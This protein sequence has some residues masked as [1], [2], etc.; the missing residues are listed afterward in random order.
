MWLGYPSLHAELQWHDLSVVCYADF[1]DALVEV[2]REFEPKL[3]LEIEVCY[4]YYFQSCVILSIQPIVKSLSPRVI[5][6]CKLAA[7]RTLLG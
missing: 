3:R 2:P 5:N 7:A 6:S 1:I 4:H